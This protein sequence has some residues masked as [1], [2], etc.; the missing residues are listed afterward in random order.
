MDVFVETLK[1]Y[2][3]REVRRVLDRWR[4]LFAA[5]VRPGNRVVM[6]P[7]WLAHCH[8][9][10]PDEWISVITHPAV[11]GA[12]LDLVLDCLEGKGSVV[13]TDG[14]QTDSCW[15]R[16]QERMQPESWR[17]AGRRRGIE[18]EVLDLRDDEWTTL[19]DVNVARRKLPGDPRGS[20][21]CDLG[22]A[23]EFVGHS[24]SSLGYY[25]ADYNTRETNESH[26]GGRHR[27]KV[28]R[29]VIEADVFINLPKMKS[30]KK[31]GITCS[32]K[33]LVGINTYKNWLPHHNEG[34]PDQGGDQFPR[35]SARNK[36]E[37]TLTEGFKSV[38]VRVPALGRWMVP[39]KALGKRLFGETRETIRS[40]NW[41][42]NDT[43]WRMVLDLNK[44]LLY[45]EP[46]GPLRPDAPS[47]RKRYLSVVDGIVGG[48]G[49]GPEAP[50]PIDAGYLVAGTSAVAVDAACAKIMGFDWRRIPSVYRAFAVERYRL[51]DF[52]YGDIA[53]V[54]SDP[55]Y[56]KPIEAV[57]PED[58]RAFRPH[59]GWRGHIEAKIEEPAEARRCCAAGS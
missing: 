45:A 56:Q 9:Y 50:D 53:L 52:A 36:I 25:G 33:N 30:H 8:K 29:T 6:K 5:N 16:I 34:T 47:S 43:L 51:C 17:E 10:R 40:G 58:V 28:S 7:N 26:A 11:I 12:V 49:N 21:V 15:S 18:V 23:S 1:S 19:G 22:G 3:P 14:P 13:I 31:A 38:L 27:Y 24:P 37:R 2:E 55:R 54:S 39:L 41:H 48:Q 44:V 32:L 35:S 46:D 42:G 20:T 59:F 57:S 4:P